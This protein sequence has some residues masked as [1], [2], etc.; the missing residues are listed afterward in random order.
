MLEEN[1]SSSGTNTITVNNWGIHQTY[2]Y[3]ITGWLHSL[4]TPHSSQHAV[5]QAV[6]NQGLI[7]IYFRGTDGALHQTHW[8]NG[9]W[10]TDTPSTGPLA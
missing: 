3:N 9:G 8:V 1:A 2:G 4:S 7:N 5:P 6:V 10:V